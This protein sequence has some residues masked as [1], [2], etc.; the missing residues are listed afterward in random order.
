M[1]VTHRLFKTYRPDYYI[2]RIKELLP[3]L[4]TRVLDYN[5]SPAIV[6]YVTEDEDA[7]LRLCLPELYDNTDV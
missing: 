7:M 4:W 2:P 5:F 1:S 3:D 6:V